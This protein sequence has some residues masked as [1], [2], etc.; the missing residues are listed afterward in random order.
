MAYRTDTLCGIFHNQALRYGDQIELLRAKF[1]K[2]GN[3]SSQWHSRTWKE[4]R[5][6]AIGLAKGLMTLGLKKGDRIVIFS[7]SRPRWIIADQAIQACS[8]I[9]VPLYPT[10][11]VE[12][13]GYMT[14]DSG[15][16]IVIA[17]NQDR[18]EMALKAK[19]QGVPIEK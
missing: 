1:D 13:L 5:D 2:N 4:T 12:E 10:L 16:K 15:S 14:S 17:S 18:G 19:A 6:E 7:E 3:P 11:T 8:A 9:G